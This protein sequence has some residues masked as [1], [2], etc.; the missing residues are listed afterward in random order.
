MQVQ[1]AGH[2]S[3]GL[4]GQMHTESE[5]ETSSLHSLPPSLRPLLPDPEPA[6]LLATCVAQVPSSGPGRCPGRAAS[7]PTSL[8]HCSLE[9]LL[10]GEREPVG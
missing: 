10:Q 7:N 8:A 2:G 5:P 9:T 6:S 3:R 4:P 1:G